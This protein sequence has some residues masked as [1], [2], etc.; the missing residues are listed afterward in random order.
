VTEPDRGC[1]TSDWLK[2][3]R[4]ARL[5]RTVKS[6]AFAVALRADPDGTHIYP[7]IARL[8]VELELSPK[9]VKEALAT[10]R[11]A[12]LLEVVHA[13]RRAGEANEYRLIQAADVLDRIEVPSPAA[14]DLAIRRVSESLRG[15]YT[16]KNL[17]GTADPAE[18]DLRGTAI[19]AETPADEEPAGYG[20]TD[21]PPSAGYGA[22]DLRGTANPATYPVP[23]RK[24]LP[25]QP[26]TDLRTAVT[27]SRA[28]PCPNHPVMKGGT[29]ADGLPVCTFCRRNARSPS[30]PMLQVLQGGAA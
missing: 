15:R 21:I 1:T 29:R 3:V 20:A 25:T 30:R 18:A 23:P 7:G 13:A 2:I 12:G 17:R 26:L 5:G 16:P 14:H 24:E 6:V 11:G 28:S 19:P 27:Q 9:V 10:L 4:R 22:T 8:S